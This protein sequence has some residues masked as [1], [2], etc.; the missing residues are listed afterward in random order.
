MQ[1]NERA[2]TFGI[3]FQTAGKALV[4][5]VEQRQPAFSTDSCASC[6]HCSSVGSI[7]VG[8]W[9][10]PWNR[11]TSPA[12]ASLRLASIPSKSRVWLAAS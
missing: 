5:E 11:T 2:Q 7:P 12:C 3:F 9:Q 4:G 1:R 6:C 10:Q 8:L